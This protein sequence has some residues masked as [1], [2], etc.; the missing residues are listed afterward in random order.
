MTMEKATSSLVNH[1]PV[2]EQPPNTSPVLTARRQNVGSRNSET[3]ATTTVGRTQL[4]RPRQLNAS[5][6]VSPVE[7]A[8]VGLVDG[9][10]GRSICEAEAVDAT[11]SR[12][13]TSSQTHLG[14]VVGGTS[15]A[16]VSKGEEDQLAERVP[17]DVPLDARAA[18]EGVDVGDEGPVLRGVTLG[19]AAVG[20]GAR[21]GGRAGADPL[22]GP[23]AVHVGADAA[24]AGADLT[25]LAPET[26]IG[27]GVDEACS[28]HRVSPVSLVLLLLL[29]LL[30]LPPPKK[31]RERR[32]NVRGTYHQ[33]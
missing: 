22:V 20:L 23:V 13:D 27:L 1:L 5:N 25:V 12:R 18:A 6:S 3:T 8:T 32:L 7:T 2:L 15:A 9:L 24:L 16:A 28:F 29:L 30:L 4:I 10:A 19:L 11:D 17:V 26:V 21:A 33:G 14:L 31:S